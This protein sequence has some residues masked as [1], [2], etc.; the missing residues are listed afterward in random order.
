MYREDFFYGISDLLQFNVRASFL[1]DRILNEERGIIKVFKRDDEVI[2]IENF[3][4]IDEVLKDTRLNVNE[5]VTNFDLVFLKVIERYSSD[6]ELPGM[7][8]EYVQGV[9]S[10]YRVKIEGYNPQDKVLKPFYLKKKICKT[11]LKKYTKNNEELLYLEKFFEIKGDIAFNIEELIEENLEINNEFVRDLVY[12]VI[13]HEEE[14]DALANKYMKN[15]TINR[16]D[17]TG[18]Q[19]LRMG[20]YEL[21]YEDDTPDIV[22]INEAVELAKKYSDDK[23]RKMINAILDKIIKEK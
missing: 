10:W 23:V 12:G 20:I 21:L 4:G 17:K 7:V 6:Y 22:A 11:D 5:D 13:T 16:I 8:Y 14:I 9:G 15:W 3:H 1:K 19:I 2:V 18:A